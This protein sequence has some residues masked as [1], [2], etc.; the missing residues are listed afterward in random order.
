VILAKTV[1]GYGWAR[2]ARAMSRTSRRSSADE[3]LWISATASTSRSPTR[4]SGP[5]VLQAAEDSEEMRYLQERRAAL[6]GYLPA[7][8]ARAAPL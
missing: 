3:A 2:P 4:R 6:G 8:R 1:K 7:R 5:A